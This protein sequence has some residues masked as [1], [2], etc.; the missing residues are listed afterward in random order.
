MH[1]LCTSSEALANKILFVA[2]SVF[3]RRQLE[4]R[5]EN[6]S[7][8]EMEKKWTKNERK[9]ENLLKTRLKHK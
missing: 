5:V 8:Q 4:K 3:E 7:T 6:I 1:I 2:F 9:G